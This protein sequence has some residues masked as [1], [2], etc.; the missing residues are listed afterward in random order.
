[1]DFIAL[2]YFLIFINTIENRRLEITIY[3]FVLYMYVHIHIVS[4]FGFWQLF[5]E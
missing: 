4:I 5:L 3:N 1:M 2:I